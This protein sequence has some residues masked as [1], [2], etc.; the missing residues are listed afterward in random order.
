MLEFKSRPLPSEVVVLPKK[1]YENS[2]DL[3]TTRPCLVHR[4]R[5]VAPLASQHGAVDILLC[6]EHLRVLIWRKPSRVLPMV[7]QGHLKQREEI[8][9]QSRLL[10]LE[11]WLFGLLHQMARSEQSVKRICQVRGTYSAQRQVERALT[12]CQ[13]HARG[14][15]HVRH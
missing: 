1:R 15:E 8:A 4:R 12:C 5:R 11:L 6:E 2:R 14:S 7:P 10:H 3:I 9:P 13:R